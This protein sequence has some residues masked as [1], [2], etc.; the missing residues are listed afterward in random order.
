MAPPVHDTTPLDGNIWLQ[1]LAPFPGRFD[2]ALR[3]ALICALTTLVVEIYQT[4]SPALTIYLVFFLNKP[5]RMGS[6]IANIAL[7]VVISVIIALL[8]PIVMLVIDQPPLRVASMAIVSFHMLFLASASKLKPIGGTVALIAAYTLD[9]L[10]SVQMGE[11]ATRGLLYAWLFI[12]IPAGVSLFINMLMA[13][14]P[15]SMAEAEIAR[16]LRCVGKLLT[17]DDALSSRELARRE[18]AELLEQGNQ[19]LLKHLK[20]A[21]LEKSLSKS[22]A[23]MLTQAAFTSLELLILIDVMSAERLT[24]PD[25]LATQL[26]ATLNEM[27]TFLD[28]GVLPPAVVWPVSDTQ[29]DAPPKTVELLLAFKKAVECFA[30]T[31]KPGPVAERENI[32]TAVAKSGFFLPDA[33]D[34]PEYIRHALKA[35]AAAMICYL[36]F[37]ILD[38]PGIHTALIT[39]YIVSLGT[40]AET[41][42]KLGLRIAGCLIGAAAGVTTMV[43]LL[44]NVT[45][46]GGLMIVVFLGAFPAAWIAV[47]SPRIAYAGYQI[48]FAFLLS[49]VQGSSPDFDLTVA[50]DRVIGILLGNIVT[51]LIFANVWP[52]SIA[53][54]IDRVAARL[55]RD[56]AALIDDAGTPTW[57]KQ[58]SQ[59]HAT[60]STYAQDLDLVSYE[61][62]SI[63][64]RDA[65]IAARRQGLDDLAALYRSTVILSSRPG[66]EAHDLARDLNAL[67]NR[68]TPDHAQDTAPCAPIATPNGGDLR[69]SLD[70]DS[71][72]LED[73]KIL[74]GCVESDFRPKISE[75]VQVRH[76]IA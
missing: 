28:R 42:E 45:S 65:W 72:F 40:T 27:A 38:W 44:P 11:F 4:P 10:G 20:M 9:L 46:I 60:L 76:A 70:T 53:D 61:P 14:A 32:E 31:T 5:D 47:G 73:A 48:V 66:Q 37:Q 59:A 62:A 54:R 50:R 43:F 35:T 56:I 49:I 1:R 71:S 23:A 17:G 6:V 33:F 19:D 2:F 12:A 39:C 69:S 75:S 63:R 64:P 58:I 74:I 13:P 29:E 7:I 3:L 36:L 41:V 16:R 24:F 30:Q 26:G 51:Y 18:L 52:V 34:N 55:L 25:S 15:R 21:Q 68:L 22:D 57:A 8:F 67:A